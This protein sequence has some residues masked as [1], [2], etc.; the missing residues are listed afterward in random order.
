MEEKSIHFII[1]GK[2]KLAKAIQDVLDRE[3]FNW[4]PFKETIVGGDSMRAN[5]IVVHCGSGRE[6]PSALDWCEKNQVVLIQAST[7]QSLP[8]KVDAPVITVVNL[9][10]AIPKFINQLHQL[11]AL[12]PKAW[13][14][15]VESHQETKKTVPGTAVEMAKA[16][17]VPEEEIVSIRNKAEQL[18]LGIPE[19][20][21]DGH[22]YHFI[23]IT[24]S[25]ATLRL[26]TAVNGREPYGY[27]LIELGKKIL[28]LSLA[29]GHYKTGDILGITWR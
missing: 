18:A 11:K 22:G 17:G 15:I 27:G 26:Q 13:I 2:G 3:G 8:E 7:G 25:G 16:L 20:H 19:E 21:L 9:V 23:T 29:P 12:F 24:D 10:M 14:K 4:L 6:L 28:E 5:T 1:A